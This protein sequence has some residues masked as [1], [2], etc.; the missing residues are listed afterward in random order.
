MF[1]PVGTLVLIGQHKISTYLICIPS[2]QD[3][4]ENHLLWDTSSQHTL[5]QQQEQQQYLQSCVVSRGLWGDA[6]LPGLKSPASGS[7]SSSKMV[8]RGAGLG[9]MATSGCFLG[10]LEL[11]MKQ[12]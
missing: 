12:R 2:K 1:Q 6:L 10:F 8:S 3:K 4:D 7:T 11:E 9:L 5:G